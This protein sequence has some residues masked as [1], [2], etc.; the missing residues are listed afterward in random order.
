[1]S[2]TSRRSLST[3]SL[4]SLSPSRKHRNGLYDMVLPCATW[5]WYY[6]LHDMGHTSCRN[7]RLIRPVL[8]FGSFGISCCSV[9]LH[10]IGKNTWHTFQYSCV[11]PKVSHP[12]VL[13]LER[14][15][16]HHNQTTISQPSISTHRARVRILTST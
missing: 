14:L 6:V 11:R 5:R 9:S 2:R 16:L 7:V 1:M 4:L 12:P 10:Q 3:I 15:T 13:D 8:I